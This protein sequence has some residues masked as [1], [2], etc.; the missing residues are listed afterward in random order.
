MDE[1]DE[2][3]QQTDNDQLD[4]WSNVNMIFENNLLAAEYLRMPRAFLRPG[5]RAYSVP[6]NM[7]KRFDFCCSSKLSI[8]VF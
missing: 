1:D 6:V 4:P 7:G 3:Q 8:E 2:Q 5:S